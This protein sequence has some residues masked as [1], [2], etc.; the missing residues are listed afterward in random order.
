M[1]CDFTR[2]A[3]G[4]IANLQPYRPGKPIEEVEREYG[5]RNAAKLASNENPLGP[6]P[7]VIESV[8]EAVQGRYLAF[9]PDGGGYRLKQALAKHLGLGADCITLG[10]G[11]NDLLELIAR[12]F[13]AS[14]DAIMYAQ[15]AFLVYPLV[16]QTIGARAQ[17]IPAQDWGHD[18]PAMAAAITPDTRVIFLA[19]P[20]N[21][22]GTCFGKNALENFLA[23]VPEDVI[24][25][26]D[27]AYG[28][29]IDT[30]DYPDSR[31]YLTDY[32]NLII[33]RT[34]SKAYG[35]AGLRVGYALS[36]PVVA[37]LLNRIRQP[38]NVNSL[39]LLA[40]EI[41][42]ADHTHLQQCVTLNRVGLDQLSAGFK[43]LGLA[44]IPSPAN[45]ICVDTGRDGLQVYEQLLRQGVI[46]RPV[47]NYG[48]PTHLRVSVGTEA[49]NARCLIA[50][51]QVLHG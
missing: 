17:E 15:Y 35:L 28:E 42:L 8:Q 50:L 2:L 33:T 4:H 38:F 29:Y 3:T 23:R 30:P 21:P 27:E 26:L 13:A 11:S 24:V 47:N 39:G 45:F 31:A 5:V 22:T 10:N 18:L 43:A 48:M 25:V 19:N 40:A 7:K 32:P 12:T 20:N 9:Y 36:S 44:Y 1:S 41:A 34:F 14:N 49:E 6:S 51:K 16:T 37:D 46:V